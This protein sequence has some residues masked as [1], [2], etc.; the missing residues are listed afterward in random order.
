M[1]NKLLDKSLAGDKTINSENSIIAFTSH[2]TNSYKINYRI[3]TM[4]FLNY[5]NRDQSPSAPINARYYKFAP[6]FYV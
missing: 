4:S 6:F 2:E 5:D 1:Y 3:P